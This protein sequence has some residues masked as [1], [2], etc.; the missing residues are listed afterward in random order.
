MK[1]KTR[2]ADLTFL[3]RKKKPRNE[4][5]CKERIKYNQNPDF[6]N[7]SNMWSTKI[8]SYTY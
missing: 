6:A 1:N 4:K 3:K 2:D 5:N 7:A 8:I